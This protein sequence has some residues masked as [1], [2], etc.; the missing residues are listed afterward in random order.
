VDLAYAGGGAGKGAKITLKV[1]GEKVGEGQMDA[2]VPGRFGVD[3]FGIG[4]DTGQPVTFEYKPPFAFNGTI[5]TVKID[6][7]DG[8]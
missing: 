5:S 6:I 1:N 2:T 3:T 7:S 8:K 4:Q